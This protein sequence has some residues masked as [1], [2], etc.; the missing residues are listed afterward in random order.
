MSETKK[1]RITPNRMVSMVWFIPLV[2]V[3]IG[4]WMLIQNVKEQ[5]PQVTLH[6]TSADGI[7]V[8]KT[9][10][11]VLS[12]EVGRVTNIKL[13]E[14]Q[15]S[16]DVKVQLN[17]DTKDLLKEDTK[18]WVVKPRIDQG[19]VQGLGTLLSGAYIEFSPGTGE[20]NTYSFNV[21][22]DPPITASNQKGLRIRL[23]STV[24]KLIPIGN[25][26]LYRDVNVGRIEKSEFNP[27]DQKTHYQ[28]FIDKPYD[29]LVHNSVSFWITSG[30]DIKTS[31]EGIKVRSGSLATM[32][33]GGISFGAKPGT[34]QGAEVAQN[35]Q[36]ALY[37]DFDKVELSPSDRAIYYVV[38]FDQSVR[39]LVT[40]APVEYKG[41][42]IGS[43]A[44]MP[45]YD[46]DE[47]LNLLK[48]NTIPVLIRI[49]PERMEIN[50]KTQD[51]AYWEKEFQNAIQKGL[52][53]K[54]QSNSLLM[55]GLF[56]D[57][58]ISKKPL[59]PAQKLYADYTVIPSVSGG[60]D[61]LQDQISSLLDKLNSLPL[62]S[63]VKELNATLA[64]VRKL[65]RSLDKIAGANDTQNI[66][67]ELNST[68]KEVR[69]TLQGISPDSPLYGEVQ[70]TLKSL[71]NTLQQIE[72]T[73]KTLQEQPNVLIFNR[74]NKDPIP[75]GR[76]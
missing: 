63:T 3:I 7:E 33:G 47:S 59:Y 32:L 4:L 43:V 18:F 74:S 21:L 9:V 2:S 50:A 1:A 23:S 48:N 19:G 39:G 13:N 69:K 75:K 17:A 56:V 16:V 30:L 26:V 73:V 67:R 60:L 64:E 25:P 14:N 42:R 70:S 76:K 34:I 20:Q 31:P 6:M 41:I 65:T 12:V 22:P 37:S 27:V 24:S 36:F 15:V 35:S 49:D 28:I 58:S 54:L 46:K 51:K 44:Q 52:H 40:D 66:P 72:P 68:L 5:G 62:E 8:N 11:K 61:Q 29:S 55:G 38:L 53:A 57:L 10:V 45:F 71:N